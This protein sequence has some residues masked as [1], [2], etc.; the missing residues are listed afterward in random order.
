MF[1]LYSLLLLLYQ[2]ISYVGP[3]FF[4]DSEELQQENPEIKGKPFI[5]EPN[6]MAQRLYQLSP[7]EVT[8]TLH[9]NFTFGFNKIGCR[10]IYINALHKMGLS[11]KFA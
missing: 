11:F 7:P 10:K 5:F 1:V 8:L 4:L 6:F 3:D 9:P 2:L